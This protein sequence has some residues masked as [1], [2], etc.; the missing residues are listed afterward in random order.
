MLTNL[1]NLL[2]NHKVSGYL[3]IL[4]LIT[5]IGAT[6]LILGHKNYQTVSPLEPTPYGFGVFITV[7]APSLA[8][9][10]TS[11]FQEGRKGT[12]LLL[13]KIA[14][15]KVGGIWY[16]I[17]LLLPSGMV[18]VAT[19][20]LQAV[21]GTQTLISLKIYASFLPV[22]IFIG[23]VGEEY[24]WRGYLLPTL[25][26][27]YGNFGASIVVGLTWALWH[28]WPVITQVGGEITLVFIVFLA[29]I[30]TQCLVF[31]WIFNHTR[32]SVLLAT[33]FHT[34]LNI[35]GR[36]IV[37]ENLQLRLIELAVLALV[38]VGILVFDKTFLANKELV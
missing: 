22:I 8:A 9:L 21:S 2:Q 7:F 23:A 38:V 34:G 6:P 30:L 1:K 18:M 3:I 12:T 25:R 28:Q 24:G 11:F 35:S 36:L 33:L 27:R 14:I 29:E 37:T 31:T 5:L 16:G 32:G 17:A 15:W 19:Y 26:Q 13:K 20:I 10:I 4:A